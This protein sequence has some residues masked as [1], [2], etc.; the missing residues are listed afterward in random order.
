M[1]QQWHDETSQGGTGLPLYKKVTA[2]LVYGT[3]G[4]VVGNPADLA[5][6]RMQADGRLPIHER[7][8]YTSVGNA[9]SRMVKQDGVLSLWTGS[10]PTV[11]RAMLVTA[12]QLATYNQIKD[13]IKEIC[14]VP[15]GLATQVVASCGACWLPWR[16]IR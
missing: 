1:K 10:A 4:A 16:R 5:M 12:A 13:T 11:T 2:A 8:N 6:V 15:E 3:T 9:L 14:L 7:R